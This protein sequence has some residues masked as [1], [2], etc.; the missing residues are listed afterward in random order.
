MHQNNFQS[1][2]SPQEEG[3]DASSERP[4]R[5]QAALPVL[6]LRYCLLG[7]S[8]GGSL[9]QPVRGQVQRPKVQTDAR[10]DLHVSPSRPWL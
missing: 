10:R 5:Y 1:S 3:N 4:A 7:C 9:S 2:F 6:N 8:T